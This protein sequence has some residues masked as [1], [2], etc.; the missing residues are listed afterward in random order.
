MVDPYKWQD[1]LQDAITH[2]VHAMS[3][4]GR[5]GH[6]AIHDTPLALPAFAPPPNAAHS[7]DLIGISATRTNV[8]ARPRSTV[9]RESSQPSL[10]PSWLPPTSSDSTANTRRRVDGNSVVRTAGEH[11]KPEQPSSYISHYLNHLIESWSSSAS[12]P[13]SA[14]QAHQVSQSTIAL[15]SHAYDTNSDEGSDSANDLARGIGS[16]SIDDS[17]DVR[18]HGKTSGLHLLMTRKV[19]DSASQE[20]ELDERSAPYDHHSPDGASNTTESEISSNANRKTNT[21]ERGGLWHFPPPGLWPPIDFSRE[22]VDESSVANV[23]P[24]D[25]SGPSASTLAPSDVHTPR[26]AQPTIHPSHTQGEGEDI[27]YL[28]AQ[29]TLEMPPIHVQE[30]L[31]SLYFSHV[32]PVLPII[33]RDDLLEA[34]RASA[35]AFVVSLNLPFT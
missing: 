31:I 18:Y 1:M 11:G 22:R 4:P 28:E 13:A 26:G 25:N 24:S 19:K 8:E 7:S 35:S 29:P 5:A 2:S 20:P 14:G 12:S 33:H 27:P 30:R 17:H 10:R 21:R 23:H 6:A 34:W 15:V 9:K 16:L 32:H 3:Q